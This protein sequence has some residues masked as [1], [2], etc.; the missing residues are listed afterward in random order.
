MS[1]RKADTYG[2]EYSTLSIDEVKTKLKGYNANCQGREDVLRN[3]LRVLEQTIKRGK[4]KEAKEFV[5]HEKSAKPEAIVRSEELSSP[6]SKI[7]PSTAPTVT[8]TAKKVTKQRKASS[9]NNVPFSLSR[10]ENG[11]LFLFQIYVLNI[12]NIYI[13]KHTD[14]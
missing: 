8:P 14:L 11:I 3:R 1:K 9:N 6:V 7:T 10:F 4:E 5:T 2:D 13:I 12:F